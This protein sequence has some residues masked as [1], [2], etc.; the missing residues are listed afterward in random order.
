MKNPKGLII[1]IIIIAAPIVWFCIRVSNI[2]AQYPLSGDVQNIQSNIEKVVNDEVNNATASGEKSY[3]T[4]ANKSGESNTGSIFGAPIT[5]VIKDAKI[6]VTSANVYQ[7]PDDT[8][9]L[10]GAVYKDMV[11]TVQ[12]YPNG[13]SNIEYGEGSG[14]I[15]SEYVTKPDDGT[16]NN[17][18]VS[19]VGKSAT[20]ICDAL[21]VRETG[22]SDAKRIDTV[23]KGDTVNIIGSNEDESWYQIQYGTKSGWVSASKSLIQVKY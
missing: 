22:A 7:Q 19:A 5:K 11:V 21:N 20:I 18:L 8:S 16:S 6:N 3:Y 23:Y 2:Q 9:S 4:E 13:W 17:T 12:D 15:K 1:A 10:V 14:W